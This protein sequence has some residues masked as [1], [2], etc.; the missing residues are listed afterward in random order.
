MRNYNLINNEV[1]VKFILQCTLPRQDKDIWHLT[2]EKKITGLFQNHR[3]KSKRQLNAAKLKDYSPWM[4]D[5]KATTHGRDLEI[6]G[7]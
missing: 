3:E 7:I 5:F 2:A 1:F 4:A 6:P